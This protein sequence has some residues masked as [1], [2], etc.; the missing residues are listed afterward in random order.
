MNTEYAALVR[1]VAVAQLDDPTHG[2]NAQFAI[3][4]A[5]QGV[6]P[7]VIDWSTTSV[8]FFE[9]QI[10]PADLEGSTPIKY[11]IATLAV[12]METNQHLQTFITFSGTVVMELAF[13]ISFKPSAVPRNVEATL[14]AVTA[15]VVRTFCDPSAVAT[16][17]FNGPVT[18]DRVLQVRRLRLEMGAQNWRVPIK[19]QFA[20]RLDSN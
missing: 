20:F 19:F 14:S 16:A 18:F 9:A 15:A 6:T 3:V 13:Y 8:N 11:P 12:L 1:D 7:F 17:N 5:A 2:F 10:D 4:A